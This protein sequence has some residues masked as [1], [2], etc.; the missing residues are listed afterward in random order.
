MKKQPA[1]KRQ[2]PAKHTPELSDLTWN[3]PFIDAPT[4]QPD[5]EMITAT[6]GF[7]LSTA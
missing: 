3:G 5:T 4:L 7:V 2:N 1:S 6:L